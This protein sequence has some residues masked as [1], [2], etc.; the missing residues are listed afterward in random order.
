MA[1]KCLQGLLGFVSMTLEEEEETLLVEELTVV[2]ELVLG[3]VIMEFVQFLAF[4][5]VMQ[6]LS[7]E[8]ETCALLAFFGL[9]LL[10]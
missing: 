7:V 3:H 1:G 6:S 5:L 4:I 10:F 8:E 9:L 2:L